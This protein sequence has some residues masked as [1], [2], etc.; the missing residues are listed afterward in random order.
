[1][2]ADGVDDSVVPVAPVVVSGEL[3]VPDSV[4]VAPDSVVVAPDSVVVGSGII[5]VVAAIP[6]THGTGNVVLQLGSLGT[7]QAS[8]WVELVQ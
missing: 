2:V 8:V 3:V 4:V 5:V 6:P 7:K 1:M